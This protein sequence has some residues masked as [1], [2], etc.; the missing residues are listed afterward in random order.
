MSLDM[1]PTITL[2]AGFAALLGSRA[3]AAVTYYGSYATWARAM[4]GTP[5][6]L[7]VPVFSCEEQNER[8]ARVV[9]SSTK[10]FV[11]QQPPARQ[12]WLEL[13]EMPQ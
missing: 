13:G 7:C 6:K 3:N 5:A 1:R 12:R 2:I 10:H 8:P 9:A 11:G 4:G